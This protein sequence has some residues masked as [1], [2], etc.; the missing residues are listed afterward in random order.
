[1][2]HSSLAIFGDLN[3]VDFDKNEVMNLVAV[4]PI[5]P[6]IQ[7]NPLGIRK[8]HYKCLVVLPWIRYE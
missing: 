3:G 6:Q 2:R 8:S 4:L 7:V 1:M 5:R